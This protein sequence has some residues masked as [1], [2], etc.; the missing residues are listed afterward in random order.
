MPDV[1]SISLSLQSIKA[2]IDI[3]KELRNIDTTLKDAEF[4]LKLADLIEKLS[5]AKIQL[6]EANDTIIDLNSEIRA[7]REKLDQE[8]EVTFKDGHYY[9]KDPK[10]GEAPG[11]FCTTCYSSE[12][13]LILLSDLPRQM[14][15]LGNY[16]CPICSNVSK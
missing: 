14:R 3:T 5:D 1:N 6:S 8:S 15:Q 12:K 13:K 10:D 9:L 2:A 4:K 16:R 11:P 7:L